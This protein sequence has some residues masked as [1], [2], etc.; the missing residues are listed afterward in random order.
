MS[1]EFN[2]GFLTI[3]IQ[4]IIEII[5]VG[6]LLYEV[7][8]LLWGSVAV[9]VLIGFLLLYFFYLVV[10]TAGMKLL[11]LFLGRFMEIGVLAAIVLFQQEIRKFLFLIGGTTLFEKS[12]I[13]SKLPWFKKIDRQDINIVSI[14]EAV[15]ALG[16]SN[17]GALI[18]ISKAD[19]LRFYED[20]GDRIDAKISKRLLMAIFNKLSP[21]HDGG[22]ILHDGRIIAARCVLP[23]T[24]RDNI[25][26]HL[27]LRHRAAIGITEIT[28]TLVVIVSEETGQLAI[29]KDGL[30]KSNLSI[31]EVRYSLNEYLHGDKDEK[32]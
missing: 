22:A 5:L 18:V 10:K 20:S 25:P 19:D 1:L 7:Y 28:N 17:I 21:L 6:I 2:I 32:S 31:Q 13:F 27:G 11:T 3:H 8:K 16:M 14:V 30:L 9:K 23:V 26:A 24:D 15:K 4:D 12:P 29:A